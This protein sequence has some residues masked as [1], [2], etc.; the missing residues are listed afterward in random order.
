MASITPAA[1]YITSGGSTTRY[2]A[3]MNTASNGDIW[4]SGITDIICIIPAN[5]GSGYNYSNTAVSFTASSGTIAFQTSGGGQRL[6]IEV[7]AG[8]GVK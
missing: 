4:S 7:I 8:L 2:I 1:L 5:Y 6:F 3:D